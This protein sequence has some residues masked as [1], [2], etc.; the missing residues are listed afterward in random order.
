MQAVAS[1]GDW[2]KQE[3]PAQKTERFLE[4]Y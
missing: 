4:V 3:L 1:I 2:V